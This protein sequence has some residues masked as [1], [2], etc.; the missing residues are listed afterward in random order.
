MPVT[1]KWGPP[2][3]PNPGQVAEGLQGAR[4]AKTG[5]SSEATKVQGPG[6]WR[7]GVQRGPGPRLVRGGLALRRHPFAWRHV[8]GNPGA[9]RVFDGPCATLP[10]TVCRS[11]SSGFAQDAPGSAILKSVSCPG[12]IQESRAF[13]PQTGARSPL[14][15]PSPATLLLLR[16]APNRLTA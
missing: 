13:V 8:T 9:Q 3:P 10:S 4:G 12:R 11:Q 14:E 5:E 6:R 16:S 15:P 7:H 2:A 1:Q